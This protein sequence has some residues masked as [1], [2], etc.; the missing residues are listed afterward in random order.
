VI[1]LARWAPYAVSLLAVLAGVHAIDASPIGVFYDDAMYAILGKSLATGQGYRYVNVPG[2]PVATHFPPGYP[3]LLAILWRISPEFPQNLALFKFAN[4]ALLGV[5]AA[6]TYR[7]ARERLHFPP[8]AAALSALAGTA[9]IPALVLSSNVVS[10]IFF[11]ALL[12]PL[13]LVA[14]RAAGGGAPSVARAGWI[15]LAAGALC[16]VRS[17]AVVLLPAIAIVYFAQ[18]RRRESLVALG[19][20]VAV[21]LPWLLW[22]RHYDQ[23]IPATLSGQYGSYG[24]WLLDGFREYGPGLL[25]AAVAENLSTCWEILARSFS[26]GR[27]AVLD[28][29]A[30]L[31][32][33]ALLVAG[34]A[35]F[36]RVARVTLLFAIGYM[37]I[38]LAWPFSPLRFVWGLWPFTVLMMFAGA[39]ALWLAGGTT[40]RARAARGVAV[41]ASAV[42]LAGALNFNARGY[43]NRWWATVAHSIGPRIQPQ[44]VWV[45][46]R[47]GVTDIV[48]ADDEGAVYLYTGRLAVPTNAFTAGQYFRPRTA[49]ENATFLAELLRAFRP[50]YVMAWAVPTQQ[51]AEIL[52][53]TQPQILERADSIPGGRVYR[54]RM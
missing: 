52:S 37:A 20:G 15:G 43:A 17:H 35:T 32:V 21:L 42:A 7:F 14:E 26:V 39:R 27:N 11:L 22:V 3:A 41:A 53:S 36:W 25:V 16:L 28:T 54:R 29:A 33:L 23:R 13:L 2:A 34:A 24:A 31:S 45:V 51:A 8:P 18:R 49:P 50:R 44:L 30:V 4:A 10:E 40:P 47:T 1:A 12:F 19:V 6:L 46:E 9:A 5:V 38:V 48:A